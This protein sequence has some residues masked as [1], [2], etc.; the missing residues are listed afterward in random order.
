MLGNKIKKKEKLAGSHVNHTQLLDRGM[1]AALQANSRFQ[2]L[3]TGFIPHLATTPLV[4][5]LA[6][7]P[8]WCPGTLQWSG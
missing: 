8:C 3:T 1:N 4:L 2:L 7:S 6:S 5:L